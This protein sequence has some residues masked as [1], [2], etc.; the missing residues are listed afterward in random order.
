MGSCA[1]QG[2]GPRGA[3]AF[4]SQGASESQYILLLE[5]YFLTWFV[6]VRAAFLEHL[7]GL[8]EALECTDHKVH[9]DCCR[10]RGGLGQPFEHT[11]IRAGEL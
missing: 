10:A 1:A 5:Y 4:D 8:G 7:L 11:Y 2:E 6:C 3:L 9:T